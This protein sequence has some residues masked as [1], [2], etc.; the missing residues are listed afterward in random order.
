[1]AF[2]DTSLGEALDING[3]KEKFNPLDQ[4]ERTSNYDADDDDDEDK[5]T[6]GDSISLN[7]ITEDLSLD[8]SDKK[9]KQP[10]IL[11]VEVLS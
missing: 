9:L 7:D 1:M 8:V 5:L 4:P 2:L 10:D 3:E 6:I 11:D